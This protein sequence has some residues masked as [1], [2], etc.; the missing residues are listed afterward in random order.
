MICQFCKNDPLY[1]L[2]AA[3]LDT[4]TFIP[5]LN[6]RKD[7]VRG[8]LYTL[9]QT[10]DKLLYLKPVCHTV[11]KSIYTHERSGQ[12]KRSKIAATSVSSDFK[13]CCFIGGKD[14]DKKRIIDMFT[15]LSILELMAYMVAQANCK[16]RSSLITKTMIK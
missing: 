14:R 4:C 5:A 1:K 2:A 12:G 6:E 13:S 15:L 10:K 3:R 7:D 11:C 9:I 8:R 16:I